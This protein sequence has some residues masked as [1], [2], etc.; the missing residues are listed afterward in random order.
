M[1]Q[2]R[3]GEGV[4]EEGVEEFGGG[5]AFGE[6]FGELALDGFAGFGPC[7]GVVCVGDEM[8]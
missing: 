7:P 1:F 8:G 4:E 2:E 3:A 5:E 6:A